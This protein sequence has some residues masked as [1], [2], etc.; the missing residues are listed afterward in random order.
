MLD[1]TAEAERK[2]TERWKENAAS[3]T[4]DM[5]DFVELWIGTTKCP[6]I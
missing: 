4:G 1:G 3:I 6:Q 5:D 2:E